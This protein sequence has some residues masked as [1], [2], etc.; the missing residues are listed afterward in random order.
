M[1]KVFTIKTLKVFTAEN[2]RNIFEQFSN[3][4][5][6]TPMKL[7]KNEVNTE[8]TFACPLKLM[9]LPVGSKMCQPSISIDG[10]SDYNKSTM[11]LLFKFI[12]VTTVVFVFTLRS[13][14]DRILLV[15]SSC[16]K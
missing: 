7:N 4:Y 12:S 15:F 5:H 6:T 14:I 1:N 2:I 8:D 9:V 16:R 3:G 10:T 11:V 13:G